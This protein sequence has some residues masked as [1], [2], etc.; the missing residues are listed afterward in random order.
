MTARSA[1]RQR[2]LVVG[3]GIVGITTAFE[4]LRGHDVDVTLIDRTAPLAG[5]S[6]RAGAGDLPLGWTPRHND[7][8]HRSWDWHRDVLG[9]GPW[10]T[11]YLSVWYDLSPETRQM[12][13]GGTTRVE[14]DVAD[15][16]R[17]LAGSGWIPTAYDVSWSYRI[18][19]KILA[20]RLLDQMVQDP[21][22]T[23][24]TGEVHEAVDVVDGV[25]AE[26]DDGRS[27]AASAVVVAVGPWVTSRVNSWGRLA[28]D[29]GVR[30]KRVYG[31]R[32]RVD[33][34]RRTDVMFADADAGIFAMP[35]TRPDE[36]ALSIKHDEW[37]VPPSSADLPD[38]VL[39]RGL[40]FIERRTPFGAVRSF[41]PRVHVDTYDPDAV[42]VVEST[43]PGVVVVTGTHGSGVRLSPGLAQD[44][45]ARVL[46]A[47]GRGALTVSSAV[48]ASAPSSPGK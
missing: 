33:P 2:L 14:G 15:F 12:V 24:M 7:L 22:F 26:L 3:A 4:A 47:P 28:T 35:A 21:R 18:S 9:D 1:A 41:E 48:A 25:V 44:A 16:T 29:A 37:D 6:G 5:I 40:D 34:E 19:P 17:L 20:R 10:R 13:L 23:L 45:V 36:I 31:F 39:Q 11:P 27:L 38:S 30:T 32:A 8:M 46:G 43:V 42:P